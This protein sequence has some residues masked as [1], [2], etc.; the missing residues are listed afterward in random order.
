MRFLAWQDQGH[1]I[2]S[3]ARPSTEVMSITAMLLPQASLVSL[4]I[5]NLPAMQKA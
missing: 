4:W 3:V 1:R 2:L 5:K